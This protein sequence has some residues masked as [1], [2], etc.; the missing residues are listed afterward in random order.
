MSAAYY[1]EN[2]PYAAQWLRNLITAGHIAAGDV[3]ERDIQEVTP[4]DLEGYTQCHFFAGIG[5]WSYA[6]R[7]AGW[8]DERTVWTGSCP[9]QPVSSAGK[10]QGHA[11]RRHLWPAFYRLIAECKPPVVFGEQVAG[12]DGREWL[13]GVRADLEGAGYACGCADLSAAGVGA[14]HIRQRLF[15][16]ADA[17]LGILGARSEF[18]QS[19][20]EDCKRPEVPR[21]VWNDPGS[22]GIPGGLDNAN[23][24]GHA[25]GTRL[26]GNDGTQAEPPT[27]ETFEQAS[28]WDNAILIPCADG[29]WRPAPNPESGIFPLAHGVPA[30]VGQLRAYGN[31]IV[32]QAAAQFIEAY[33]DAV[34]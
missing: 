2:E 8:P 26:T 22:G 23:S 11:D 18:S 31:A 27:G 24:A 29:K 10:R 33:T 34:K 6:L 25:L 17:S 20:R 28:P 14:P 1:N 4:D 16:M 13:S 9:C 3:D 21:K 7:L 19:E 30:R 32:P 12:K 5:G 15:W